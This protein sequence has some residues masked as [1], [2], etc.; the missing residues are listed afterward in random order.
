M[1]KNIINYIGDNNFKIYIT[2]NNINILN[3]KNIDYLTETKISIQSN[4]NKIIIEG[5]N[6]KS[7][8]LLENEILIEGNIKSIIWSNLDE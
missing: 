7:T 8:K 4:N 3:Y 6:L 2:N 5:K 1:L